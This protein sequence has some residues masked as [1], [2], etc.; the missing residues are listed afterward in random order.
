MKLQ[1]SKSENSTTY[2]VAKSFRNEAGKITSKIVEKLG[3]IEDLKVRA[4]DNDPI[5]WVKKYIWRSPC[6]RVFAL[7]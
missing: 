7:R 5:M 6:I 1:V 2:Y 4:G 3:S